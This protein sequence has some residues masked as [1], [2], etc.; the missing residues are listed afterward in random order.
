MIHLL[1]PAL[2]LAEGIMAGIVAYIVFLKK[3][4]KLALYQRT[5][6][7]II[8][9]KESESGKHP[10]VRFQPPSGT[11]V[12]FESAFGGGKVKIGDRIDILF[13]PS[14][15]AEAEIVSLQAQWMIPL[16]LAA[17]AAGSLITAPICYVVLKSQGF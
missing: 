15:P 10:V 6:G 5:R 7:D 13:N 3:R 4:Q 9:I 14:N 2:L 16:I 17:G 12:V 11:V 8:E 1:I